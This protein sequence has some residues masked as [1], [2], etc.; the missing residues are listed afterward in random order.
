MVS[1]LRPHTQDDLRGS[2]VPC[3]NDG[4]MELFVE[5]RASEID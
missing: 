3:A 2:V 5:S 4:R 1:D